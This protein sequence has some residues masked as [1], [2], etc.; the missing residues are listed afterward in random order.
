[1]L[2]KHCV[3][4]FICNDNGK[5][6]NRVSDV[7]HVTPLSKWSHSLFQVSGSFLRYVESNHCTLICLQEVLERMSVSFLG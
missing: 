3:V 1:V 4:Y 2:S 5:V 7:S 6:Q